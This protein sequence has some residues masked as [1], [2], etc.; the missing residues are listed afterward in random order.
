M[1]IRKA[2]S[3]GSIVAAL[4]TTGCDA[5]SSTGGCTKDTDCKGDRLCQDGACVGGEG[6]GGTGTT[7]TTSQ[8]FTTTS[9]TTSSDGIHCFDLDGTCTCDL[10]GAN[11]FDV[12]CDPAIIGPSKCCADP[13][14]PNAGKCEC[15]AISCAAQNG[16]CLCTGD[17]SMGAGMTCNGALCCVWE[18]YL[19]FNSYTCQCYDA[20]GTCSDGYLTVPACSLDNFK[21]LPCADGAVLI[22]KCN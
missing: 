20:G 13:N 15:H 6:G 3:F 8:T 22:D 5:E 18:T 9:Q 7:S 12:H 2:I 1:S 17:D 14:W 19:Q 16:S 4:L 10:S 21:S 11:P